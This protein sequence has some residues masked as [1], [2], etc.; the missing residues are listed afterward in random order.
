MEIFSTNKRWQEILELSEKEPVFVLK[1]SN[2]CPISSKGYEEVLSFSQTF[3]DAKIFVLI[4]QDNLELKQKISDDTGIKHESPQI[5]LLQ[6]RDVLYTASHYEI[7]TSQLVEEY[8]K[9]D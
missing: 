8:S 5:L 2:T 6:D 3:P 1:H 7:S 4:V 9:L